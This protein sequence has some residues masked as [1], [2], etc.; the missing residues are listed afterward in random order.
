MLSGRQL[1]EQDVVLRADPGHLA[2]LVHVVRVGRVVSR[3]VFRWVCF[4][5]CAGKTLLFDLPE[6]V[7][8]SG[9]DGR[10]PRQHVEERRLPGAVVTLHARGG[11]GKKVM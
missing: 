10:H 5:V 2:D 6:N 4:F 3:F 7:R 9:R 8:L 1:V 11:G